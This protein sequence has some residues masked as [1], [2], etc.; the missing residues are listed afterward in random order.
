MELHCSDCK[1][2]CKD[3]RK[4]K[5]L[6]HCANFIKRDS[7]MSD[8]DSAPECAK[9]EQRPEWAKSPKP[10]SALDT[11]EGGDHYKT[12]GAYQPWEVLP[13]WMTP[14]ELKGY[15]KGTAIAYLAREEQKGGRLDIKK[16]MHTLQLYLEVTGGKDA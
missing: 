3:R 7:W 9:E 12:M 6:A 16:A 2:L 10:E 5:V 4:D 8:K 13:H 11:Q 1:T 15:A 14:E